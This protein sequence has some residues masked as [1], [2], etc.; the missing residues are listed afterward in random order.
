M[1]IAAD[2]ATRKAFAAWTPRHTPLTHRQFAL[3]TKLP[4]GPLKG[5]PFDPGSDPVQN[6]ICEQMD[7]GAWERIYWAAPPQI[8]GKTQ[9]LTLV[10]AMRA[11]IELG[12]TVG[13]GLP[14]LNDLDRGWTTKLTPTIKDAGLGDYLPNKGPGSKGGRPPAVTFEDPEDHSSLGSMV[15]L[16]GAAKQVTCRVIVVDEIDAWRD[17]DGT[18]R[19]SDLEDVW[20]RADSFQELALR[21]GTGTVET[22]DPT[23]SII[24]ECVNALGTGT[25]LW[26]QCPHCGRH[27]SMEFANFAFE[28]SVGKDGPD[29]EH[30][31]ATAAYKCPLCT[32]A[33]S[34]DDRQKALRAPRF[35]HKGQSVDESG[36]I[37]G[38]QPR[39]KSLGIRTHALDCV[40]TSL[41]AIAEKQCAAQYALDVH[42]NHEPMRK[43]WRYQRVEHYT[44][45]AEA[46]HNVGQLTPQALLARAN[47]C[48]WGPTIHTT[49]RDGTALGHTY[50]RHHADAPQ[51]AALVVAGI[52]VQG[53]RIYLVVVA[54]ARDDTQYDIG[55]SYEMARAD[56][57]AWSPAELHALLDRADAI[58]KRWAGDLP[59]VLGGVD[60]GDW[61]AE[62]LGW[63]KGRSPWVPIKG[64]ARSLTKEG[65]DDIEGLL[66]V[67][68]G[69]WHIN[70]DQS[71]ALVDAGL[72]RG[73]D[74]PGAIVIPH[75]LQNTS[76]DKA[77][78]QHYCAEQTIPDPKTGKLKLVQRGRWDWKDA[79]RYSYVLGR[80]ALSR[81]AHPPRPRRK[82]GTVGTV[83]LPDFR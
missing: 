72:R 59:F 22:D 62:I 44:A 20:A 76:T 38:D 54:V 3:R 80:V 40:L 60:T 74:A 14:T 36:T 1:S 45:D 52:D 61:T 12:A 11:V 39:T 58:V 71:R 64:T 67:H 46:A 33:W 13:Y 70:N 47:S 78:L 19:W 51:N 50:S 25:R 23:Q 63:L 26:A 27:H 68:D 15:F 4:G 35:V 42:G 79:R 69:L 24:L 2:Q 49:D 16:A 21:F 53:N 41:G 75:G 8:A 82:Y 55:W 56:H 77:L 65:R 43:F 10:P 7:S 32:K 73:N 18:P 48:Q 5:S 66:S 9:L 30:A 17:A 83:N 34:E 29:L 57:Q 81:L 6:Y 28:Y 31:K 37:V